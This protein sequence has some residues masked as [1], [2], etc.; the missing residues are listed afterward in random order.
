M[1]S[2]NDTFV[3]SV[4]FILASP[5]LLFQATRRAVERY[6]FFQLAM[7]PEMR[8]E[9]GAAISLVGLW[10]CSCSFTYRGHLLR[11]CPVCGSVPCIV[12]CYRC[13]VTTKLPEG[14]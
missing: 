5:I 11:T 2:L 12:R 4:L 9:C 1:A 10:R 6:R 13:G 14:A 7:Q 8:C 3:D